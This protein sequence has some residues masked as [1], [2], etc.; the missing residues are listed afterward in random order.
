MN[1]DEMIS[2]VES[3]EQTTRLF[4]SMINRFAKLLVGR[5]RKVT[6]YGVLKAL[7]KEL[8]EFNAATDE[9]KN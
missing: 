3:A 4:D 1:Y 7:K 5:L 6:A 2:G 9:W 8:Q